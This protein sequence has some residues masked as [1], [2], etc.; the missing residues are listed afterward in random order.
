MAVRPVLLVHGGAG[1]WP[2]ELAVDCSRGIR[3]ALAAGWAVLDRGGSA[4]DAA[5]AAVVSME[6]DET[7]NAGRGSCLTSDGRVQMDALIVDGRTLEAGGVA[8]TE[9]LRNPI[10]AARLVLDHSPHVLLAGP[11]AEAF[12]VA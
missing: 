10:Q 3:A 9:R 1:A 11:E 12:A 6:D 8:L 2:L 7:F 5:E 4:L